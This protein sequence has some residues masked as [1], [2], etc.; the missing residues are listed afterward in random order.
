MGLDPPSHELKRHLHITMFRQRTG[1]CRLLMH[2]PAE[3]TTKL[4]SRNRFQVVCSTVLAPAHIVVSKLI[5][6][7]FVKSFINYKFH[8]LTTMLLQRNRFS[9]LFFSCTGANTHRGQQTDRFDVCKVFY[10]LQVSPIMC[11][12]DNAIAA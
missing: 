7:S 9:S 4:L 1:Y 8:L 2:V 11:S 12:D 3:V 10:Q 5:V 6:L